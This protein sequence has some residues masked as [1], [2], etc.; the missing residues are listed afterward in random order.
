MANQKALWKCM[1]SIEK[2]LR[3]HDAYIFGGYVRD[4]I[5]HDYHAEQFYINDYDI[6]RYNDNTYYPEHKERCLIPKDIDSFMTTPNMHKFIKTLK[7]KNY[8]IKVIL[9]QPANLYFNTNKLSKLM[10]S[11]LLIFPKVHDF[12]KELINTLVY[13]IEVDIIHINDTNIDLYTRL[14]DNYDFECN[15]LIITPLN[16]FRLP[17]NIGKYLNPNEKI[18]KITKICEDII[19]H[20]AIMCMSNI[21]NIPRFRIDK[22]LSKGWIV[23][24]IELKLENVSVADDNCIIC[25]GELTT[26]SCMIKDQK[27]T[28]GY[29]PHCFL[30]MVKHEEF[31]HK[32]PI[33]STP[34]RHISEDMKNMIEL[35]VSETDDMEVLN[36]S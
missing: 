30:R 6:D 5:I 34:F 20:R 10:Y 11:K 22:M 35:F 8:S 18:T 32:C 12:L 17:F 31:K 23:N 1:V 28:G 13:T 25:I 9:E 3:E 15:S 33:C 24:I 29:H 36:N 7:V 2:I 21:K 16:E 4:K 27:C 14:L 26:N 19:K